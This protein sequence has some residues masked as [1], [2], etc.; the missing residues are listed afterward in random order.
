MKSVVLKALHEYPFAFLLCGILSVY[1]FIEK[2]PLLFFSV[3]VFIL[4]IFRI[5][6]I[7]L[8]AILVFLV[9]L[10]HKSE[11]I[12]QNF[13][14]DSEF[15]AHIISVKE[16]SRFLGVIAK[17]DS[18]KKVFLYVPKKYTI[19]DSGHYLF[20]AKLKSIDGLKDDDFRDYLKSKNVYYYG[21]AYYAKCLS[22]GTILDNFRSK[23]IRENYYFLKDP[24]DRLIEAA[25]FGDTKRISPI[26]D[27]FKKTQTI[28]IL[29]VSGV[30]MSFAFAI[31]YFLFFKFFSNIK[32]FYNRYNLKVLASIGGIVFTL[33][34]FNISG[35]EIPAIR[36]FIMMLLFV[37]SII[38]GWQKNAYNILFFVACVFFIFYGFEVFSDIS[39]ILSFVMTFFA[40]YFANVVSRLRLKKIYTFFFFSICMGIFSIPLS[41]HYFGYVSTTSFVSNLILDP[42]FGFFIMPLSFLGIVFTFLPYYI[43]LPFFILFDFAIKIYFQ[44]LVFL[45]DAAK[46]IYLQKPSSVL[47]VMLYLFGI[48]IVEFLIY[49]F[50]VAFSL[51]A[52]LSR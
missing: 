26:I 23:I 9:L 37:F 17:S 1:F 13:E 14:Q 6:L 38:F 41:L 3:A 50:N 32:L 49:R 8:S 10:I 44:I 46:I 7:L 45:S 19:N 22:T 15:Q 27:Y 4:A 24:H 18:S 43:K 40:I 31:F 36:S 5:K 33:L 20:F 34:Y 39:F 21:F 52:N 2:S 29:S 30:H 35:L 11:K 25:V 42:Y 16:Q 28:H 51:K 12:P 48:A 47:V